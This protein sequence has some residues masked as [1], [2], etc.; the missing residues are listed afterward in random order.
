VPAPCGPPAP[1]LQEA[2]LRAGPRQ[3]R[4]LP[5]LGAPRLERA[6]YQASLSREVQ[7]YYQEG[8]L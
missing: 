6:A 3:A 7:G 1:A 8:G 4:L 2:A 5:A